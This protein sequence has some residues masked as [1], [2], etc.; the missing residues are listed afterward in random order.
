M[1]STSK[2][3]ILERWIHEVWSGG[4]FALLDEL[5]APNFVFRTPGQD[6]IRGAMGMKQF[7][8]IYRTAFPDLSNTIHEQIVAGDMLATRGTA[9][10]TH[11]AP[12]GP[13]P[14]SGNLVAVDW[15]ILSKFDGDRI[16]EQYEI[17]DALGMMQQ[18]GAV[19]AAA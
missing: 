18:I 7:I 5:A 3:Q 10:G 6:A 16:A 14:A 19:P 9:R 13:M 1:I 15:V 11:R 4:D 8:S 17:F 12:L 2:K